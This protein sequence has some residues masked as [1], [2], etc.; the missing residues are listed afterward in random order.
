MISP[1]SDQI[2]QIL[3]T[4]SFNGLRSLFISR[5]AFNSKKAFDLKEIEKNYGLRSDILIT[6]ITAYN[7]FG[8]L[9]FT[10]NNDVINITEFNDIVNERIEE[11]IKKVANEY[12][13]KK[14]AAFLLKYSWVK[15]IK[16]INQHF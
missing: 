15:S 14:D 8:L 10:K 11:R 5:C 4:A 2:T 16:E 6:W 12:D 3:A 9:D 13:L 1:T 7:C